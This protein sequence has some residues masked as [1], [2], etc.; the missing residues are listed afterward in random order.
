MPFLPADLVGKP[1]ILA[2]LAYA[3]EVEAGQQAIAPFRTLAAPLADMIQPM[4][5]TQMYP[6][7][8]EE[9][10]P[11]GASRNLFMDEIDEEAARRMVAYLETSTA[12]MAVVQIR[13]LGG[14]MARV[15]VEATAF[16]HR[17]RRIMVNVAALVE[18]QE[19]LAVHEARVREIAA[20]LQQGP[21]AYVNFVGDEGAARVREAYPGATWERLVA[22]KTQY[23]P[24]NLFRLN[25]NI[26]PATQ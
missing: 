19:Q 5:Y 6:P 22:V 11:I 17:Q 15:L 2:M 21:G 10:H 1:V 7:D 12:M 9:Y 25:H 23:D 16:A 14:A 24:T 13:V 3:G 26:P 8:E 4:P 20:A 18:S